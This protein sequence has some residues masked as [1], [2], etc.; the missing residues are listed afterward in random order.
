[1]NGAGSDIKGDTK[2]ICNKNRT[3]AWLDLRRDTRG[4]RLAVVSAKS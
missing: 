2:A 1:M 4:D 3:Y